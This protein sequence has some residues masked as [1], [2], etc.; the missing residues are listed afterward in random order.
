MA[1]KFPKDKIIDTS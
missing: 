1:A